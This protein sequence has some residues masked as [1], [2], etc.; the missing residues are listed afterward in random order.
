MPI[1]ILQM[2]IRGQNPALSVKM[3]SAGDAGDT[4]ATVAK[5]KLRCSLWTATAPA[6]LKSYIRKVPLAVP[7]AEGI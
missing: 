7:G 4:S 5:E 2:K 3:I 6:T 1:S